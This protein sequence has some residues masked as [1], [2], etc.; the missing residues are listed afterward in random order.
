MTTTAI[1]TTNTINRSLWRSFSSLYE[2]V[3]NNLWRLFWRSPK[4]EAVQ[5]Q[6]STAVV[7]SYSDKSTIIGFLE[8]ANLT[9]KQKAIIVEYM[10]SSI[11]QNQTLGTSFGGILQ[12]WIF[13]KLLLGE[14][15]LVDFEAL[16]KN[17]ANGDAPDYPTDLSSL[18]MRFIAETIWVD[19]ALLEEYW[20]PFVELLL[21]SSSKI[22]SATDARI[23][24]NTAT[25]KQIEPL[26]QLKDIS[27]AK[28]KNVAALMMDN[29]QKHNAL[30]SS[31]S[32]IQPWTF[33]WLLLGNQARDSYVREN[34][35]NISSK[36]GKVW[37]DLER[38]HI[39]HRI[40][41]AW[42]WDFYWQEFVDIL[43]W[44]LD[45]TITTDLQSNVSPWSGTSP[46]WWVWG[47]WNTPWATQASATITDAPMTWTT[48]TI[49]TWAT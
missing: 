19:K 45:W 38:V 49:T 26:L 9:E 35:M 28:K 6:T 20:Q 4:I 13:V 27:D 22:N 1:N 23:A 47:Q 30:Y 18:E 40:K 31:Y 11:V 48:E 29:I 15:K 10:K 2:R 8:L 32:I 44:D 14:A 37:S 17:V 41:D 12:P 42:L 5:K 25:Y 39:A 7:S 46:S 34:A 21:T 16:R 3:S 43:M 33:I 36:P 24:W